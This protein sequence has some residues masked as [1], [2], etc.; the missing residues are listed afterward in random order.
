M[1]ARGLARVILGGAL[2][3]LLSAC[4]ASEKPLLTDKTAS[5]V[6]FVGKYHGEGDEGP[7]DLDLIATGSTS[8]AMVNKGERLP[9]RFLALRG[10][11]YL[12]QAEAGKDERGGATGYLYHPVRLTD[13]DLQLYSPDCADV[14]GKFNGLK[15]DSPDTIAPACNFSKLNG[16]KAMALAYAAKV[17]KGEV[18]ND[19]NVL[20]RVPAP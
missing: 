3:C 1:G 5:A 4:W 12:M 10:N 7:L 8:Y 14:P 20:K 17:E 16:L 11:W 19:P 18:E 2:A 6:N 15:R 9:V 13:G